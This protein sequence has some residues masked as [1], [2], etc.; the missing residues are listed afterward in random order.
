MVGFPAWGCAAYRVFGP[1][2]RVDSLSTPGDTTL[3]TRSSTTFYDTNDLGVFIRTLPLIVCYDFFFVA[4]VM[5]K[6]LPCNTLWGVWTVL[7]WI[8]S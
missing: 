5:D 8:R 6:L 3:I 7:D 4:A 1:L 2:E